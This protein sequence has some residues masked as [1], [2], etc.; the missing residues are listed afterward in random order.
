MFHFFKGEPDI[1]VVNACLELAN[2]FNADVCIGLGGGSVLDVAK[3]VA[4]AI[5]NNCYKIVD[6]DT[7]GFK[8]SSIPMIMIS[9][10]SGTGFRS[11]GKRSVFRQQ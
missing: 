9:T 3:V 10:T 7:S 1:E 2:G 4:W 11:Y 8:C 6:F 5:G